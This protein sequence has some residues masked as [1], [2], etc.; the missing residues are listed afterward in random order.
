MD[1]RDVIKT[2]MSAERALIV[3]PE[4]TVGH[5]VAG[6]PMVYATPMM[7]L[8][9]E[10]VS[11]DAVK[12]HLEPGW[13]TVGTKVDIRH[14]AAGTHHG[15][16]D[17]GGAPRDR[18]RGRGFR[19][20]APHRRGSPCPWSRQRRGFYEAAGGGLKEPRMCSSS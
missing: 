11:G 3:P 1:A 5:L 8:E 4:R 16:G 19:R 20:H 2:G 13:A 15:A 12:P 7:I 9:I 14:L 10:L 18:V 6:M 17:R